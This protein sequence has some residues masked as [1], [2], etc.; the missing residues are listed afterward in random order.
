MG[1]DLKVV[2]VEESEREARSHLERR[3][4]GLYVAKMLQNL[5]LVGVHCIHNISVSPIGRGRSSLIWMAWW[6]I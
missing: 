3:F 4:S 1:R 5:K 6:A 2:M